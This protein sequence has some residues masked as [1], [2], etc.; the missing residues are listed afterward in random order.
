MKKRI[1][2]LAFVASLVVSTSPAVAAAP[3]KSAEH[4]TYTCQELVLLGIEEIV[5]VI[6]YVAGHYD[7][8]R[9][10][11]TDYGPNSKSETADV[12]LVEIPVDEVLTYCRKNPKDTVVNALEKSKK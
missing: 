9:D 2:S 1:A 11:W 3:A 6:Y 4:E 5:P 8:K 7:A 10:I 12:G